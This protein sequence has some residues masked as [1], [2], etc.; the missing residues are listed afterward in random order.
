MSPAVG[1]R[2]A[3]SVD[4]AGEVRADQRLATLSPRS[5]VRLPAASPSPFAFQLRCSDVH[6]PGCK[7]TLWARRFDELVAL[8]R[9]HGA[10]RHGLTANW[11]TPER[12]AKI[13]TA[14]MRPAD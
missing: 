8:T 13:A 6:S 7:Q 5:R 14:V 1:S 4:D 3:T 2:S 11:Y 9:D 10:F 12:L